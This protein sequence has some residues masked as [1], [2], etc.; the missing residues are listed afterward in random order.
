MEYDVWVIK[1]K[2]RLQKMKNIK[3]VSDSY[4]CSN[5]GACYA[6]CPKE[7]ISFEIT[8]IGRHYATVNDKVVMSNMTADEMET[9][10]ELRTM[11]F[12]IAL[13]QELTSKVYSQREL[14]FQNNY[15][16]YSESKLQFATLAKKVDLFSK[17]VLYGGMTVNEWRNACNMDPIEGGD[18]RIMR[19]DAGSVTA[20]G[21]AIA[22]E[23]KE[24]SDNA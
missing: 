15:I 23:D 8:S 22:E 24:E 9:F 1:E 13:G 19:L 5:C 18:V 16:A 4:L 7:A 3:P 6:I 14:T 11:P 10:Y 20:D 2:N 12:L 21:D 17:V